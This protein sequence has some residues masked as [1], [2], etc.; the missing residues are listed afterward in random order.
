MGDTQ[1]VKVPHYSIKVPLE[2]NRKGGTAIVSEYV[3]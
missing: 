2:G 1:A 3:R